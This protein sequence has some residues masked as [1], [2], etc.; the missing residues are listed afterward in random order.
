M[1]KISYWKSLNLCKEVSLAGILI[2][3]GLKAFDEMDSFQNE[4]EIFDFLY[5]ISVGI[6]RLEKI[7]LILKEDIDIE[8]IQEFE[9][10]LKTHNHIELMNRIIETKKTFNDIQNN[11]LHLLTNFY[12]NW[13][14]DRYSLNDYQNYDKEKQ[15]FINFLEKHYQLKIQNELF[16]VTQNN[17][18]IKK[19]IGKCI[20]K[21][22]TFLYEQIKLYSHLNNVFTYEVRYNSKA[23]K[24]FIKKE[25]D[26]ILENKLWK[27]IL[28]YIL[29]NQDNDYLNFYKSLQPLD[30]DEADLIPLINTFRND[31]NKIEYND[32]LESLY[33]EMDNQSRKKRDEFLDLIGN[34]SLELSDEI[35]Y[36][37]D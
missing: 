14:Y 19:A 13:R 34:E 24:I 6:E 1:D 2:Y 8:K 15:A 9:Q 32:I 20:G 26:F 12:K 23:Y 21:I 17:D 22:V 29:N 10:S 33:E 27:E 5:N 36:N 35:D 7:T 28:V 30:F 37:N 18:K 4:E 31:L 3:N 25:F 11:F 16:N